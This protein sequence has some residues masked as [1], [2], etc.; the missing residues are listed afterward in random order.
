MELMG[1]GGLAFRGE[2]TVELDFVTFFT[3]YVARLHDVVSSG[4]V[5]AMLDAPPPG[6]ATMDGVDVRFARVV[7]SERP[8]HR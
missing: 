4:D 7:E 5:H 1:H 8:A 2:R 3:G 6:I